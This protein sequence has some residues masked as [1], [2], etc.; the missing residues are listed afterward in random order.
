MHQ[1]QFTD[2]GRRD[3]FVSLSESLRQRYK[4]TERKKD[5]QTDGHTDVYAYSQSKRQTERH[6]DR[7]TDRLTD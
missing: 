5:M 6:K 2:S 4:L 1:H 7:Q 3:R